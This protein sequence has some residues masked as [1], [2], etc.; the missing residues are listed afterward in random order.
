[1][2]NIIISNI[3]LNE[4]YSLYGIHYMLPKGFQEE[5]NGN[6]YCQK[7]SIACDEM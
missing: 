4:F 6:L 5:F 1:M 7:Y 3:Y 2:K